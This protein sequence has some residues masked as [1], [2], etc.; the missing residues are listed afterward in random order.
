MVLGGAC[1]GAGLHPNVIPVFYGGV[2]HGDVRLQTRSFGVGN[3]NLF[4]C[5]KVGDWKA[6]LTQ[7]STIS[8]FDS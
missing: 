3:N 6:D 2:N 4:P 5:D 7:A 1:D 8:C